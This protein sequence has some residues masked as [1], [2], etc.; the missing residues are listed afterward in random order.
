[1]AKLNGAVALGTWNIHTLLNAVTATTTSFILDIAGASRISLLLT[2]ADHSS[3]TSAFKV[4][5]SVD[6]VTFVD[7]NK[8]ITNKNTTNAQTEIRVTTVT[9]VADGSS[10]VSMDL[11]KSVYKAMRVVCTETTDGTHTA[12]ALVSY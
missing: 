4:Q 9:L 12:K 6:G 11:D 8:L 7:F 3:G 10:V 1:M 2:R 5:V